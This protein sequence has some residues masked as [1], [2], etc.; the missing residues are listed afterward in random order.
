MIYPV[1]RIGMDSFTKLIS[2]FEKKN[3]ESPGDR[4]YNVNFL[5][6]L[7]AASGA[8]EASIWQQHADG[9]LFL[10]Y[11]TNIS[12]DRFKDYY[13]CQGEGISGAVAL[14]RKAIA[15]EKAWQIPLHSSTLDNEINF[16][17]SSMISAPVLYNNV[18]FGVI[19]II[20][21]K[22]GNNFPP[23]WKTQLCA[24]AVMYAM[25]LATVNRLDVKKQDLPR[26]KPGKK[27]GIVTQSSIV[28]IS[29]EILSVID[30][31]S[32]AG[33]SDVPVIIYGETGTG[34][35]LV[36][37][38]IHESGLR[39]SKAFVA[40]NCAALPETLLESE[41]FGH[42]KG[43]F[44]GADHNRK[45]KFMEA[46]GGTLFLDE[47]G[48]LSL[49]SQ[50]KILRTLQENKVTPLGSEKEIQSNVRIIAAT[51]RNL[52]ALMAE[53]RF[54]GDLY[55]RLCGMEINIPPLRQ[56]KNDIPILSKFF[57]CK[58]AQKHET[59]M[60]RPTITEISEEALNM[61]CLYE[62]PGNVRQLEQA[63]YAALAICESDMI[64]PK[65]L[66]EWF[67]QDLSRQISKPEFL[68]SI[69]L[70]SSELKP[71]KVRHS[72]EI[73]TQRDR[74]LEALEKTKY[75]GTGRWNV[76]AAAKQLG[77]KRKTF[78]YR[79]EIMKTKGWL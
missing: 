64:T 38:K 11:G 60:E 7:I 12:D 79:L 41:L 13:L 14:S 53:N 54:R 70:L 75:S 47:I 23:E 31:A 19:N 39:G 61:I 18:L 16:K 37:K 50:A 26:M 51:N 42:V 65:D 52:P 63:V 17:T 43:A 9:R 1:F 6:H 15:V 22:S 46:S 24:V 30:I 56:R 59:D 20:N 71:S 73:I 44:T 2:F 33:K 57:I 74:F 10:V 66:P 32:K 78:I 40:V 58:A 21:H 49:N 36:A 3:P 34:K 76:A 8:E 77:I 29:Q 5:N 72:K 27:A 28:G 67:H 55:Y 48:E 68:S 4:D 45:G 62:W 69:P 25:A 35:E